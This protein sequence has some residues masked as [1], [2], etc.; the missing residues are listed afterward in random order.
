MSKKPSNP[1][2]KDL[3]APLGWLITRIL[4]RLFGRRWTRDPKIPYVEPTDETEET[5]S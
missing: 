3:I 5:D 4:F 2:W 1:D